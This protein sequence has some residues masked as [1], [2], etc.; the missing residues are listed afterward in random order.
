MKIRQALLSLSNKNGALDFARELV[1]HGVR[2][3]STG[4]TARMLRD[5]GLPVSEVGDY[6][7][8]P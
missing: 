4:G 8:F 2:L 7:G 5:A 6:T 1:A 3:L